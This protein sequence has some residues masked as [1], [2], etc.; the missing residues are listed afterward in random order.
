MID[1]LL[2]SLPQ[3]V[4]PFKK[5]DIPI[6]LYFIKNYLY[7]D[8][9]IEII[10]LDT[11]H[12]SEWINSIPQSQY[13]GFSSTLNNW[14]K[15]LEVIRLC[16]KINPEGIMIVGGAMALSLPDYVYMESD[17]VFSDYS[18]ENLKKLLYNKTKDGL[19]KGNRKYIKLNKR[20][21]MNIFPSS[22]TMP[23]ISHCN[24]FYKCNFCTLPTHNVSINSNGIEKAVS[25]YLAID[26]NKFYFVSTSNFINIIHLTK[27]LSGKRI[28]AKFLSVPTIAKMYV[29]DNIKDID[30]EFIF[31]VFSFDN[32]VLEEYN[33]KMKYSDII[34]GMQNC[35][36][37]G[38]PF[39]MDLFTGYEN[40][41]KQ[42]MDLAIESINKYKPINLGLTVFRVYPGTVLWKKKKLDFNDIDFDMPVSDNVLSNIQYYKENIDFSIPISIS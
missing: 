18:T 23:I 38:I 15:T 24:C 3:T 14:N 37:M 41:T 34:S 13:Y 10:D 11:I 29:L 32:N 39:S 31:D 2:I 9:D 28:K 27:I 8:F 30:I 20:M 4:H 26:I 6:S 19:F 22:I 33:T 7:K 36:V 40:E 42:S 5:L 21:I 25:N 35:H 17:I 16:R 12:E 1:L